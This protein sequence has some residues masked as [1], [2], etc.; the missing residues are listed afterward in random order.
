MDNLNYHHLRYFREVAR[1][2][3]LT[4]TAEKV[5]LSQSA[6]SNPD[7]AVGNAP[8]PCAVRTL[9]APAPF[10]GSWPDRA[11]LCRPHLRHR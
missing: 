9:R 5:N 11:G 3:N 4:R 2:G 10:D 7:Q 8:R 1:E 6:L